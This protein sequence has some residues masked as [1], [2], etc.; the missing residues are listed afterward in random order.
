MD[1]LLSPNDMKFTTLLFQYLQWYFE[2]SP[3]GKERSRTL[4][5]NSKE[6]HELRMIAFQDKKSIMQYISEQEMILSTEDLSLIR[7]LEHCITGRFIL[8]SVKRDSIQLLYNPPEDSFILQVTP[9]SME[10]IMQFQDMALP[11]LVEAALFPSDNRII[12]D[13]VHVVGLTFGSGMKRSIKEEVAAAKAKH[14]IITSLP[15][16]VTN[17]DKELIKLRGLMSN[18]DAIRH[19]WDEIQDIIQYKPELLEEYYQKLGTAYTRLRRKEIKNNN[20]FGWFAL[21]GWM[22]IAGGKTREIAESAAHS[23]IS[24]DHYNRLVFF[25]VKK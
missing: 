13:M 8:F 16:P 19:N 3:D 21:Y 12:Y 23:F 20:I 22:I 7:R 18:K 15:I 14:G 4:N 6:F 17:E 5:V 11:R 1:D 10:A 9:W 24:S 2:Q 25:E